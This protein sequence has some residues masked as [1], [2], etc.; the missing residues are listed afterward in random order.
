MVILREI[1][2]Y[3]TRGEGIK[4]GRPQTARTF[5]YQIS[6]VDGL[7]DVNSYHLSSHKNMKARGIGEGD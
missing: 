6:H 3:D 1:V 7:D 5:N 4:S 2:C